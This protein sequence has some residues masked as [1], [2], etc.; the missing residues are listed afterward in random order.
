LHNY[1]TDV[2]GSTGGLVSYLSPAYGGSD[3]TFDVP[4]FFKEKK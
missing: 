1:K 2:T 4:T 3:V